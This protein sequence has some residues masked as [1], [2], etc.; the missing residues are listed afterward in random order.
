[1]NSET[2]CYEIFK[3]GTSGRSH[4]RGGNPFIMILEASIEEVF[5]YVKSDTLSFFI[6]SSD[7]LNKYPWD[8]IR[9]NYMILQRYDLSLTDL[10]KS[11][12]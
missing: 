8:S 9:S 1:M 10:A 11:K 5:K 3:K 2:N 7:T 4:Q 12:L 6:F